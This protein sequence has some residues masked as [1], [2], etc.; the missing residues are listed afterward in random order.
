[1]LAAAAFLELHRLIGCVRDMMTAADRD[2]NR[3][4]EFNL[5]NALCLVRMR[6]QDQLV[7]KRIENHCCQ[8]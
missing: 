2:I 1:L 8:H 3:F 5:V 7:G 6:M 4:D